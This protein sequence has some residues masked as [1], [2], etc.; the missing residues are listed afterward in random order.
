MLMDYKNLFDF[1]GKRVLI[2]GGTGTIGSAFAEAFA[3]CGAD[4]VISGRDAEK[5]EKVKKKC[6]S[7]GKEV[8]FVRC[9]LSDTDDIRAMVGE[10]YRLTGGIDILCNHGG[11][12][13]RKPALELEEGEWDRLIGID[14]K[15]PFFTACEAAKIMKKNNWGRIINT[16]SVS[17]ARGHSGLSAY[18]CAKGGL[19]QM[20]KV[21]A[22]EW[23]PYGIT[24][25]AV[26]PGYVPSG[27]TSEYIND[28]EKR[29][30]LLAKIPLGRFGEPEEI[31]AAVL[32]LASPGGSYITG[33]TIYIEG[34][35]MT[36]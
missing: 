29:R 14:L 16:A 2:T 24:V 11:F 13:I 12:S 26:A 18:A 31:A 6:R 27:Q 33:Q 10:T 3:L 32:F 21:L 23:A 35:R 22:N 15:A 19:A 36:D 8:S 28:N 4:V 5:A 20:T 17:S 34:G 25:N 1:T 30:A 9:D 7:Q